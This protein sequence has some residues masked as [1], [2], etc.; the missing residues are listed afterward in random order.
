MFA[1]I[2]FLVGG[3]DDLAVDAIYLL[4]RLRGRIA[5]TGAEPPPPAAAPGR[6]AVFVPL[7][8]E[9]NVI[10]GMLRTALARFDHP[11]YRIYVGALSQRSRDRRRGRAG[12]GGGC[13]RPPRDRERSGPDLQGGMPQHAVARAAARRGP[14]RACAPPRWCSTMPRMS[15]IRSSCASMPIGCAASTRCRSR[16]CRCAIPRRASSRAIIATSSPR[17]M[18]SSCSCARRWAPEC[19]LAGSAARSAATCWR[20]SPRRAAGRRSTPPA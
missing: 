7:W 20:A 2:W 13:A 11:D 4:R 19:P 14:P 9:A 8:R 18:P 15:S 12:G 16:C 10:G 1:A 5:R 6:I 17:R 3:V